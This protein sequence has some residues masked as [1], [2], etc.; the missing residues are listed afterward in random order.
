MDF[1]L[2]ENDVLKGGGIYYVT[3]NGKV[4]EKVSEK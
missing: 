3:G 2:K 1:K 4:S